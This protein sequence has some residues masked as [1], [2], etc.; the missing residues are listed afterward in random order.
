M[1]VGVART[2][3]PF[4]TGGAE[5]HAAGSGQRSARTTAMKPA[6][7]PCPSNGTPWRALTDSIHAARLADLS[8][9]EGVP[10]DMMIGL[11]I[12]SL[13]RLRHP[14]PVFWLLHQHRQAYDMW[15]AGTSDLL[16]STGR[17]DGPRT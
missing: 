9:A 15:H 14:N 5:R 4:V 6:K 3:V 7:S 8:E 11:K 12:P 13:S 16:D 10:I 1:R 17:H 2:Q